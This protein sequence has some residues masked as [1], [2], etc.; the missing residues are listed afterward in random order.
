MGRG[1]GNPPSSSELSGA[2]TSAVQRGAGPRH[3]TGREPGSDVTQHLPGLGRGRVLELQ[4]SR[5]GDGGRR[6]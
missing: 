4:G 2:A 1:H 6:G 3:V 5:Q